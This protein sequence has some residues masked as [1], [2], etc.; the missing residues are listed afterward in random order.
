MEVVE[1]HEKY[2]GFPT[3]VG[4]AKMETFQYIKERLAAKLQGWQGRTLSGARKDVLIQVVA[5]SLPTY[6]MSCFELTKF[7]CDDLQQMC[8]K[9]WWGSTDEQCKIH[10][11][12]WNFLC[13]P[14]EEGGLGFRDLHAFNQAMLAKQGWRVLQNPTSLV[15]RLYKARYFP[16]CSFLDAPDHSS[17]SFSWRSI[18]ATRLLLQQGWRWQVGNGQEVAVWSDPWLATRYPFCPSPGL[19]DIDPT[20]RVSDLIRTPEVW[21][22]ELVRS[23]FFVEEAEVILGLVLSVRGGVDRRV[24][25]RDPKGQF[26]VKSACR[27]ALQ[28]R[29]NHA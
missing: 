20:Q 9:F 5:Q 17:P 21:N 4:R 28:M 11:K 29:D 16:T 19:S 23:L 1:S 2:L 12:S 18:T 26:T 25:H 7:L 13:L 14:K 10:W 22:V 27:L 3:Y 24:W 6:A 15:A 8:V